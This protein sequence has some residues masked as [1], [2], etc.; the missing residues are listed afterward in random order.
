MDIFA[1][2]HTAHLTHSERF[3]NIYWCSILWNKTT[4]SFWNGY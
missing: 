2:C 1:P 4:G 3:S